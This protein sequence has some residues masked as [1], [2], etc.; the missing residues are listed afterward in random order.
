MMLGK[1]MSEYTIK[2]LDQMPKVKPKVKKK[3][4]YKG[5]DRAV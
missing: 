4:G 1:I 5:T 3:R 2:K